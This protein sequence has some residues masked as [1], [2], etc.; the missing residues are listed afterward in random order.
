M[1]AKMRKPVFILLSLMLVAETS[2]SG[3]KVMGGLNLSRYSG[4]LMGEEVWKFRMGF[5]LGSGYEIVL[6]SYIALEI[7]ALFAQKG[8]KRKY[9]AGGQYYFTLNYSLNEICVPILFKIRFKTD[10]SPY[11]LAGGEFSLI[12]SHKRERG[13]GVEIFV[14]RIYEEPTEPKSSYYGL[15]FGCG[16]ERKIGN[17]SAFLEARYSSSLMNILKSDTLSHK[18]RTI[19]LLLGLKL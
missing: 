5:E 2:A 10:S 1:K 18:P 7:D 11:V 14:P 9:I 6:N 15:V 17:I 13:A 8:S 16:Y 4:P 19:V 12:L 3:F